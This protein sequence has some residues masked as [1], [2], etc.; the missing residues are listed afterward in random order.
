MHYTAHMYLKNDALDSHY[1][2]MTVQLLLSMNKLPE[3]STWAMGKC[4]CFWTVLGNNS[5]DP[6]AS[7]IR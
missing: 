7:A 2:N 5:L 3:Y 4:V 6:V 1:L